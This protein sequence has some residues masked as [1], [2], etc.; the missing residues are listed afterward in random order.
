MN[1]TKYSSYI[2][3]YVTFSEDS[4]LLKLIG[5]KMKKNTLVDMVNQ[6]VS[7]FRKPTAEIMKN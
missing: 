7:G 5:I 4:V 2:Q 1:N 3:I 6:Q